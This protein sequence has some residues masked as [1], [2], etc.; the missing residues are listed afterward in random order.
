MRA[1]NFDTNRVAGAVRHIALAVWLTV[2][3]SA[4]ASPLHGR[5]S[6]NVP[7]RY[8]AVLRVDQGD[9][10]SLLAIDRLRP[11]SWSSVPTIAVKDSTVWGTEIVSFGDS[12]VVFVVTGTPTEIWMRVAQLRKPN[13][14]DT[15]HAAASLLIARPMCRRGAW[16][17]AFFVEGIGPKPNG[18]VLINFANNGKNPRT[19][20]VD[21]ARHTIRADATLALN[22][23]QLRTLPHS[24]G[25][26][27][28]S[29]DV[30][31]RR[32][33]VGSTIPLLLRRVNGRWSG[34]ARLGGRFP[35]FYGRQVGLKE[36]W[37]LLVFDGIPACTD[38]AS[39]ARE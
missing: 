19:L 16:L 27:T 33:E 30:D 17:A 20:I 5:Q 22:E 14:A 29:L 35:I 21:P 9:S 1:H 23:A 31:T 24:D 28:V 3:V 6:P 12:A 38:S 10:T 4:C 37:R 26:L 11:I 36:D 25:A 13:V 32:S 7:R 15:S 2:S 8:A 34:D 18:P 39:L